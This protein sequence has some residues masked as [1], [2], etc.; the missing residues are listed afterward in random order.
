MCCRTIYGSLAAQY[1]DA[2][3][4]RSCPAGAQPWTLDSGR[5][6]TIGSRTP[7]TGTQ[8]A[9]CR[10]AV[11]QSMGRLQ[12]LQRSPA[13]ETGGPVKWLL[14]CAKPPFSPCGVHK[15]AIPKMV[16]Q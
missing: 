4:F 16:D 2:G 1:G 11:V 10:S 8:V 7:S 5:R 9:R 3:Y 13:A 15:Q 12:R 14:A 6:S